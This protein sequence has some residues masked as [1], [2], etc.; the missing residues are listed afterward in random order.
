VRTDLPRGFAIAA[1]LAMAA[2]RAGAAWRCTDSFGNGYVLG[3]ALGDEAGFACTELA[4]AAP[5]EDVPPAPETPPPL[6]FAAFSPR[7]GG[8]VLAPAARAGAWLASAAR[9]AEFDPLIEA[10]ARA[11]GQD[12]D[13]LR[14]IVQVESNFDPHAVSRKGAI[15]LMQVMP[16]TA[17]S[18]GLPEPERALLQPEHNLRIGALYLRRLQLQFA[19]SL[20]LVVAAYNAGEGAVVRSGFAVPPYPETQAYVHDV[21]EVYRGLRATR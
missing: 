9:R 4:E 7:R 19:G 13:L 1:M 8:L 17:A 20:D 2:T 6:D 16:S 5:A 14:A 12:A 21:L 11:T 3:H 18:L 10:A 15:G